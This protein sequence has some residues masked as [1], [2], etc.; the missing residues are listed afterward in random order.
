[1][2]TMASRAGHPRLHPGQIGTRLD[3]RGVAV[4][5]A[6]NRAAGL[7]LAQRVGGHS[8]MAKGDPRYATFRVP[9]NAMLEESQRQPADRSESLRSG[10]KCPLQQGGRPISVVR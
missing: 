9:G 2:R 3:I 10:A 5:A 7:N 8:R 4:E 1:S 6:V